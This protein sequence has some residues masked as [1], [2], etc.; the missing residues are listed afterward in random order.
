MPWS[1]S[2]SSSSSTLGAEVARAPFLLSLLHR[3]VLRHWRTALRD[4]QDDQAPNQ[5]V[6][7]NFPDAIELMVRGL[8]S[9]LP[10]TETLGIVAEEIPGPVGIEFR[11]VADKM[12]IGRTMEAALQDTADRLGTAGVPV[13]RHHA[14]HSARDRRQP[15]RDAV[16]PRRRASQ[17]RADEA[18]DPR[19]EL[20]IQGFGLYRRARCRSSSSRSCG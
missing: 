2:A 18:Q 10:I 4:R 20:G 8:R 12:K 13:L 17:A 9:G 6:Q 15:R 16:E 3:H 11:M 1:A 14:G 5:Q 7:L 19:H